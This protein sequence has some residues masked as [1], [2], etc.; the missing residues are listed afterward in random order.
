MGSRLVGM[1][2]Q[3][4]W[5][6]LPD[7]ARV[8]LLAMANTARDTHTGDTPAGTYWA[9]HDYLAQ[10]L[11][12]HPNP[13]DADRYRVTRAFRALKTAGA[14]RELERARAG[15]QA[16][17]QLTLDEPT[18]PQLPHLE[19]VDNPPARYLRAVAQGGT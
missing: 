19:P 6:T 7:A 9:G 15:R 17:Y 14:I 10:V 5:A 18:Q 1:A 8:V 12:G 16:V 4:C 2:L 13:T 3:P 11:T